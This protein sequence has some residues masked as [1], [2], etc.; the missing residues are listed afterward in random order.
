MKNKKQVWRTFQGGDERRRRIGDRWQDR[1]GGRS[2]DS[3]GSVVI[4]VRLQSSMK[5]Q[6]PE[7][8]LLVPHGRALRRGGLK[9]RRGWQHAAAGHFRAGLLEVSVVPV[10]PSPS[11]A[12]NRHAG[13]RLQH[14]ASLLHL[15][16]QRVL[17]LGLHRINFLGHFRWR[18]L[19]LRRPSTRFSRVTTTKYRTAQH[20]GHRRHT[21]FTR[22]EGEGEEEPRRRGSK[23]ERRVCSEALR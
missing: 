7:L 1:G 5:V 9:V 8:K 23:R 4:P 10:A 14:L 22:D 20:T 11:N 16:D 17:F 18:N 2:G 15:L 19:G 3:G 6:I 13:H 12:G 21:L